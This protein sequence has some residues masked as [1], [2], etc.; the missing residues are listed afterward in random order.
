MFWLLFIAAAA[1][2]HHNHALL[3]SN[4][5]DRAYP[6]DAPYWAVT[7]R[8]S[9]IY[10]VDSCMKRFTKM[11]RDGQVQW[12]LTGGERGEGSIYDIR[13]FRVDT[14]GN[15]YIYNAVPDLVSGNYTK[16]E[17]LK[18]SPDGR[19]AGTAASYDRDLS[20]FFIFQDTDE[21][22]FY[23]CIYE[24]ATNESRLM[25]FDAKTDSTAEVSPVKIE[26]N[27][28]RGITG[29]AGRVTLVTSQRGDCYRLL[30]GG[31]LETLIA[32]GT[33]PY[34]DQIWFAPDGQLY[35]NSFEDLN[36]YRVR[37]FSSAEV[38]LS[39]EKLC[40]TL[41]TQ[42][43][44]F[45]WIVPCHDGGFV[46]V[47]K[48]GDRIL[49]FSKNARSV[50]SIPQGTLCPRLVAER[51]LVWMLACALALILLRVTLRFYYRVFT[52]KTSI[53]IQDIA[54]F[55]PILVVSIIVTALAVYS[56][57]YPR[58]EQELNSRLLALAQLGARRIDGD[59]VEAVASRGHYLNES[60]NL[61]Q[62]QIK[63]VINEN[64]DEW[65]SK[66][67]ANIY[68]LKNGVLHVVCDSMYY[69][70]TMEPFPFAT[71]QHYE[72]VRNGAAGISRYRDNSAGHYRAGL[73]P[74]RNK[75]GEI[76]GLFE[77]CSDDFNLREL[78]NIF[79]KNLARG[80]LW[81]LL[82]YFAILA[83]LTYFVLV[84]IR[85]LRDIVRR[86]T[87]GDLEI[88]V[89]LKRSDELGDLG[90]G[91]NYMTR[92]L[93]DHINRI[94]E[95]NAAYFRFVP[96]NFLDLLGRESVLEVG[97]G[98]NVNRKMAVLFS[99]IRS[100]TSLSEK[101]TPQENFNFINSYLKRMG[102]VIRENSGFIDKYIGD[103][104]M[105][106]FESADCAVRCARQMIEKLVEYNEHRKASGYDP[107]AIGIG[108]HF[109]ELMLGVV[110]E[111]E[112]INATVI[113]DDVNI[114][115]R[116]EELC[117]HFGAYIVVSGRA[118]EAGGKLAGA[119]SRPLG[120]VVLH[121]KDAPMEL[122]EI[123][124]PSCDENSRMKAESRDLFAGAVE[125]YQVGKAAGALQIF[126]EI[127]AKN[128]RDRAAALFVEN[129]ESSLEKGAIE[130]MEL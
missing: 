57:I 4:P 18:F 105:A 95:L 81:A 44:Y 75:K 76:T 1:F 70:S 126:R 119:V 31:S 56:N 80:V 110:G 46:T 97:A 100:F 104:I 129:C 47:D 82:A 79:L 33:M 10:L 24:V 43:Y 58:F 59:A 96:K 107:I 40:K 117:K 127:S 39:R 6:F 103:A 62:D 9:N 121:E 53:I 7:D 85:V 3:Y 93:K 84:S 86:I 65:N 8:E 69:Y 128:P 115:S 112:R 92:S 21:D 11:T 74:V 48:R 51:W 122:F 64:R 17:F 55:A 71:P 12:Y 52:K 120:S 67:T 29:V 123:V 88:N 38:C 36:I 113:S 83:V 89:A 13:D 32:S 124:V 98:D 34:F 111:N 66:F 73:A 49:V 42:S 14:R 35:F 54:T 25:S 61:L 101:M 23:Y 109:G 2:V 108:L 16:S 28:F 15:A 20:S 68:K 30:E 87:A 90:E 125:M 45:M 99:D 91:I 26:Y 27:N 77:V 116:L 118:M 50:T 37:D 60:Y 78:E 114:A 102:P 5:F 72:T 41:G 19:Y 63:K 94:M 22:R 130:T 106:L